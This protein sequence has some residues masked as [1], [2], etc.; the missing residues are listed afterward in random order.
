[1]VESLSMTD[2]LSDV[3]YMFLVSTLKVNHCCKQAAEQDELQVLLMIVVHTLLRLGRNFCWE[4]NN[5]TRTKTG[6]AS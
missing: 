2:E 3:H 4:L 1:M 6:I 5:G